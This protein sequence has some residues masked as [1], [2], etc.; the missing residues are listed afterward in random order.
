MKY[1]LIKQ[2]A[3]GGKCSPGNPDIEVLKAA[4]YLKL[5][6]TDF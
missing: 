5:C 6:A 1:K 3:K 2:Y 4:G